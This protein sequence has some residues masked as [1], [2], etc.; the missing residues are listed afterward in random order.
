MIAFEVSI[1]GQKVSMAGVGMEGLLSAI[2]TAANLEMNIQV[3]GIPE[4]KNSPSESLMWLNRSLSIG[5]T[6]AIK[7]VE[8]ELVDPAKTMAAKIKETGPNS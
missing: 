7:I 2:V 5:D 1:N 3:V 8:S 6:V 4:K